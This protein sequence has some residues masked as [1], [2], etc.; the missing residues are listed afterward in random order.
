MI[1]VQLKNGAIDF[2]ND[3]KD[4]TIGAFDTG[5]A[6]IC[7]AFG[8]Q[9]HGSDD[10]LERIGKFLIISAQILIARQGYPCPSSVRVL[11][12]HGGRKEYIY[13]DVVDGKKQFFP[14]EGWITQHDG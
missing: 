6:D 8:K 3:Y 12:A 2:A 5:L 14:V 1:T 4:E 7:R 13:R 9:Y 10:L 11:N